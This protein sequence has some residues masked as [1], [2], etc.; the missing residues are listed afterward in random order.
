MHVD[1]VFVRHA[2]FPSHIV[3]PEHV[4]SSAFWTAKHVPGF[5]E[6]P[7]VRHGSVQSPSQQKPSRQSPEA[8]FAVLPHAVPSKASVETMRPAMDMVRGGAFEGSFSDWPY[9]TRSVPMPFAATT[10][11]LLEAPV[12]IGNRSYPGRCLGRHPVAVDVPRG[13]ASGP[14]TPRGC[15]SGRRNRRYGASLARRTRRQRRKCEIDP[16][17]HPRTAEPGLSRTFRPESVLRRPPQMSALSSEP[18][19]HTTR[20]SFASESHA[21][22]GA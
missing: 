14:P 12:P 6:L 4:S 18:C 16:I 3:E 19:A 5:A 21:I 15:G 8:H 1:P 13:A 2:P 20:Y 9:A 11:K 22:S 7:H 17:L 10:G